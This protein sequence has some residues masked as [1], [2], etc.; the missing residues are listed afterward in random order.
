MI[1]SSIR[2]R[3]DITDEDELNVDR[4]LW[5]RP[6]RIELL[7]A[8]AA[9]MQ[10]YFGSDARLSLSFGEHVIDL[11]TRTTDPST[12][13]L[14]VS[15]RH[16]LPEAALD[17]ATQRFKDAYGTSLDDAGIWWVAL[18]SRRLTPEEI[19]RIAADLARRND[20]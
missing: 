2:E 13:Q 4:L 9:N 15:V 7:E 3:F 11:A 18:S 16:V 14:A 20:A 6:G 5:A 12:R 17:Q 1:P 10:K 8:V 19:R